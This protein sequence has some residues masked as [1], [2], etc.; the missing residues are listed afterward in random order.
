MKS[1]RDSFISKYKKYVRNNEQNKNSFIL[2]IKEFLNTPAKIFLYDD[3]LII[4]I[5]EIT[6]EVK[7]KI[8]ELFIN[9]DLIIPLKHLHFTKE[10]ISSLIEKRKLRKKEEKCPI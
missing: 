7:D 4:E 6:K 9:T 10:E 8:S 1:D 3:A 5:S 2:D